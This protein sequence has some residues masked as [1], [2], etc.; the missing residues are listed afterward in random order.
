M[1]LQDGRSVKRLQNP[2][3]TEDALVHAI[4]HH[5]EGPIRDGAGATPA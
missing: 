3:V 5:D 4:A 1:V 2:G